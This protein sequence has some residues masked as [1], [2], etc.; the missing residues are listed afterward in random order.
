MASPMSAERF[1]D[2]WEAYKGT[3]NQVAG[4][5]GLYASLAAMEDAGD[6]LDEHANW[7]K[8][9]SPPAKPATKARSEQDFE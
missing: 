7:A 3:P 6:I 8:T 2:R 1:Q 9:F 5:W 4:I